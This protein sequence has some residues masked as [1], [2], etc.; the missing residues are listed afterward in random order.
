MNLIILILPLKRV[1]AWT[2]L[3]EMRTARILFDLLAQPIHNILE[4]DLVTIA[5]STPNRFDDFV[6]AKDKARPAHQQM[7]QSKFEVG[8]SDFDAVRI[9]QAA[10]SWIKSSF[11]G[12]DQ[13]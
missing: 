5:I 12:F 13:T 1:A 8:Q 9:D 6:Q 3:Q 10:P 4:Q 2:G 7:Q 11:P